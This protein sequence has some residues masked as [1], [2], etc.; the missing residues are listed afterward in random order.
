MFAEDFGGARLR[1]R[2]GRGASFLYNCCSPPCARHTYQT[3]AL[4]ISQLLPESTL[5]ED[6]FDIADIMATMTGAAIADA[7]QELGIQ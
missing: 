5:P 4:S 3:Q 1:A 2:E 7:W 6:R